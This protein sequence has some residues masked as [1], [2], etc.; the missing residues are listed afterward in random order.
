MGVILVNSGGQ[1]LEDYLQRALG[2]RRQLLEEQEDFCCLEVYD[3]T[4]FDQEAMKNMS[5]L[6][7]ITF[8]NFEDNI[9]NLVLGLLYFFGKRI[10]VTHHPSLIYFRNLSILFCPY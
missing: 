3:Y 1:K 4:F 8:F 9:V 2:A 7:I 10:I 5:Y 6:K